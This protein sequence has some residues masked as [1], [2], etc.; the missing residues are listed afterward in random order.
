[1]RDRFTE[2]ALRVLT[3]AEEEAMRLNHEYISTAHIFLAL[4]T[5]ETGAAAT[6]LKNIN[7][8]LGKILGELETIVQPG[9]ELEKMGKLYQTPRARKVIE[10]SAEEARNLDHGAV[11]PEH[12]LLSL[13]GDREGVPAQILMGHGLRIED[14]CAEV[15]SYIEAR[16]AP[17]DKRKLDVPK[18]PYAELQDLPASVIEDLKAIDK[19]MDQVIKDQGIAVAARDFDKASVLI[20]KLERLKRLWFA[21]ICEIHSDPE[22]FI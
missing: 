8:D 19:E 22:Y 10:L 4:V 2:G 21:T 17:V 9:P 12:I 18:D 5:D 3:L 14:I 15:R 13:I 7:V 1:M 16:A 6:V 20:N 11:G